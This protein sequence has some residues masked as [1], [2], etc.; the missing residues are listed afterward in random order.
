MVALSFAPKIKEIQEKVFSFLKEKKRITIAFNE[1]LSSGQ[2]FYVQINN[3][4]KIISA[5]LF[6]AINLYRNDK[7]S[8]PN[9]V[10]EDLKNPFEN[11]TPIE[12]FQSEKNKEAV[13]T[14]TP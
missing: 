9:P 13:P 11:Y 12:T 7:I 8:L 14:A 1:T 2:N 5:S 6:S 4:Y 10:L 3:D